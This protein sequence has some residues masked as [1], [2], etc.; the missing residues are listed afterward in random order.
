MLAS[1]L[2][3]L[4]LTSAALTQPPMSRLTSGARPR[5]TTLRMLTIPASPKEIAT[6]ASVAVQAAL[7]D[8]K[9]RLDVTVPDG[10]CFF[11]G[12]GSQ[13]IG[14]PYM[15]VDPA[16]RSRGDR[17]L[18]YL[19]SEMFQALGDD[20]ACVLP[21][22]SMNVAQREWPK[23]GLRTRLVTSPT[24]LSPKA[25]KGGFSSNGGGSS[26]SV[27]VIILARANK[28]M[29]A[30]LDPIIKPLG[31]EVVVVLVNP[32]RLK[33]GKGRTGFEPTFVLRDNPHPDW[34]G[35]FLFR[36]YPEQWALGVAGSG[37]RPVIHGR[38]TTRPTLTE[39][40]IGFKKIKDDTKLVA[41]GAMA[42]VGAAAALERKSDVSLTFAG[43]VAAAAEEA[44]VERKQEEILPGA[45][46]I[47]KFFG[48]EDNEHGVEWNAC[49][50]LTLSFCDGSHHKWQGLRALECAVHDMAQFDLVHVVC[51]VRTST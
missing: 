7:A 42:A 18:A 40:E 1:Q 46:K 14:D 32:V 51:G 6:R 43:E 16:T 9:R 2:I 37:G 41:G 48:I 49:T 4:V 17:E 22:E 24:A 15:K 44:A 31:N 13:Q 8:G 27:R 30:E 29:L 45:D 39:L 10:M 26:S 38:S 19:V 35:G 25:A 47:K 12:A 28:A 11:A 21:E 36:P 50:F 34:R 20:V 33:S 5:A 23:G 3:S